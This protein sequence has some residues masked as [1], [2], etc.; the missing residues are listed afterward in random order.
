MGERKE[1]I[2]R[3]MHRREAV[4]GCKQACRETRLEYHLIVLQVTLVS[5]EILMSAS[6][7]ER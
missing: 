2:A 1:K 6:E 7:N 5:G 3:K 4:R